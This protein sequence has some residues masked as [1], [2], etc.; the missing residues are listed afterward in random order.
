[1]ALVRRLV[2]L[3]R[4]TRAESG[5]KTRQ[6]LSR[7]LV[8]AAGFD[9]LPEE[10]RAAGRR[11]AQRRHAGLAVAGRRRSLV[12]TTAQGQLPRAGQAVRQ[13]HPAG[14]AGRSRAADAAALSRGAARGHRGRRGRRRDGDALPRR[15]HRH[16]DAR[17]RAGRWRPSRARPSPST[18]SS[19]RAAPR[20]AGPRRDPAGP[21]GPQ[22]R[23]P[24]GHRPDRRALDS[25]GRGVGRR[26]HRAR[27]A[28]SRTRSSPRTSPGAT[29]T[30]PTARPSATSRW[31]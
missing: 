11:G 31:A 2:E 18:W 21:G 24:R 27:H 29:R 16:R 9:A 13:G 15:G 25:R 22:E 14:R 23:R 30:T 19:P 3:G 12:D 6:P 28:W 17:A 1:M 20:R 8:S 26:A 10:L 4:A 5:V 7:A